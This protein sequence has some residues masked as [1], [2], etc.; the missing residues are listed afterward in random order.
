MKKKQ[1]DEL[2]AASIEEIK[3]H[4]SDVEK[5]YFNLKL[6]HKVTPI[7]NP[8]QLKTKRRDIARLKTLIN[9][10]LKNKNEFS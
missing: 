10:K 7:K 1:W 4:L 8:L 3:A 9:E 6:Q 2:K 5:E